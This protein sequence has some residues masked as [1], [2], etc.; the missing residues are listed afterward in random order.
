ME[1]IN[2]FA[3]IL[4]VTYIKCYPFS[5]GDIRLIGG[6]SSSEGTVL[7]FH[8]NKWGSICDHNWDIRDAH[9]VC[10]QLGY[11][12]ALQY[13]HGSK[14]GRGR[15]RVWLADVYCRGSEQSISAC[16]NPGWGIFYRRHRNSCGGQ[17]HS[18]GVV[19]LRI[20]TPAP[21]TLPPTSN[22][23]G[24]EI[25]SAVVQNNDRVEVVNS[26]P[27]NV[28]LGDEADN[29]PLDIRS[30]VSDIGDEA[31]NI[32]IDRRPQTS[33]QIGR[34][35]N[36]RKT[37]TTYKPTTRKTT[38]P[39]T[40]TTKKQT[41]TKPSTT[42]VKTTTTTTKPTTT[43]T[44]TTTKPTTTTTTTTTKPTTTTTTTTTKPTTTTTT[45][46]TT[47]TTT[48]S[49]PNPGTTIFFLA[50]RLPRRMR[51]GQWTMDKDTEMWVMPLRQGGFLVA[52][53]GESTKTVTKEEYIHMRHEIMKP[54][55]I[56]T[57]FVPISNDIQDDQTVEEDERGER[58]KADDPAIVLEDTEGDSVIKLEDDD[59]NEVD[60]EVQELLTEKVNEDDLA[61]R[62]F[63][64]EQT[65]PLPTT[66]KIS[67]QKPM[68]T[69]TKRPTT[70]TTTPK[71]TTTPTTTTKTTTKPTSV[72]PTTQGRV[73]RQSTVNDRA[74]GLP[75]L[76]V[77]S[78][79]LD[80]EVV[81]WVLKL[82]DGKFM[83]SKPGERPTKYTRGEYINMRL[84]I[85]GQ[86]TTTPAPIRQPNRQSNPRPIAQDDD[87][88]VSLD[89]SPG[90]TLVNV[91]EGG[92]TNQGNNVNERIG[93]SSV[94]TGLPSGF[95]AHRHGHGNR[96][97]NRHKRVQVK[98]SGGRHN[99][100]GRI[101]VLP[102][103]Q[104]VWG[105]I[106]GDHW[107]IREAMVA[108]RHFGVG[109][110]MQAAKTSQFGGKYQ[111]KY[112]S[113][114]RCKGT[115]KTLGHCTWEEHNGM[116]QCGQS[117]A[118]AAIVCSKN[119]PDLEPSTYMVETT[120]FL[121]DRH[122]YYLTC[123]MEE[124]CLAKSAYEIKRTSSR[125]RTSTRRL[126]RFSSVVKN[127]GTAEFKPTST[128]ADWE[129]HACHMHYHS[130]EIFAHYDITDLNGNRVA[131]GLK[132]SFCLE[133]SACD[134]GVHP[135]FS[136]QG[137]GEQGISVGCSDNYM[138]DIDCQWIDITDLKPGNFKF[139]LEVNPSLFVPEISFENNGMNCD[140]HYS[141]YYARITNCKLHSI[142]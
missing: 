78:W 16:W 128:R 124:N 9:V 117:D 52:K 135:K 105:V 106:C 123:A 85:L 33:D 53:P 86:S 77:G 129:W 130:M 118:V 75:A 28:L 103:D 81:L 22:I 131:E 102:P 50:A 121:Q 58:M 48:T 39:T 15:R 72:I 21:T 108:C 74:D 27:Y 140:L 23:D 62:S 134:R 7:V 25:E 41:T 101:E 60:E 133:D 13:V 59:K 29:V 82:R 95:H 122:M 79:V 46:T 120:S 104:D 38:S 139:K 112:Y 109:Y 65:S 37:T 90:R 71:P 100:D 45:P 49:T 12:R 114:V 30:Q 4:S 136:C 66:Q 113:R 61:N 34:L 67:T 2:V 125:W 73:T 54:P 126:L 137:Y 17:R 111:K 64:V 132:A 84:Q 19:C 87:P 56:T 91:P 70:T 110:A 93:T 24:N 20:P 83:I 5:E 119:L 51:I 115:E 57:P 127:K 40:T 10:R 63:N 142:L 1:L 36:E 92:N 68:T 98:L 42:T 80:R 97:D 76:S 89:N 35:S 55:P 88:S 94:N 116:V 18:A 3:F 96:A 47:P 138:A 141:G 14:F 26:Q 43:T 107:S 32:P 44:T 99:N 6:S 31:N 11:P 69:T 8:D